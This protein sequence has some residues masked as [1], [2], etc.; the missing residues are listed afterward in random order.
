[1]DTYFAKVLAIERSAL[2]EVKC[3]ATLHTWQQRI[4]GELLDPSSTHSLA[5]RESH[6]R[7]DGVDFIEQWR[8]L[9]T[10]TID[11]LASTRHDPVDPRCDTLD[12]NQMATLVLAAL[13]GGAALSHISRDEHPLN[14]A[15]DLAFACFRRPPESRSSDGHDD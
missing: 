8:V 2:A 15:L 10:Q 7:L 12:S 4:V 13:H 3:P 9:I 6:K 1:M 11:R 5:L 14:A